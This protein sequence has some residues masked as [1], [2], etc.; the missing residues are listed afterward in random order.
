MKV[1]FSQNLCFNILDISPVFSGL[2]HSFT[3]FTLSKGV[4]RTCCTVSYSQI[5]QL[6]VAVGI[7]YTLLLFFTY[8]D[9]PYFMKL[10]FATLGL[11]SAASAHTL[12][13]TFFIDGKNQGDGT[14]V[15]Q[16]A[17]PESATAPIGPLTGD[18]MA[19]GTYPYTQI[20]TQSK[21]D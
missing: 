18:V 16:P 4:N 19:C 17:D 21:Q 15:R 1:E 11:A 20:L 7:Y 6:T 14:C 2:L 13:T 10:L 5:F 9:T 3:H 8:L 12:F